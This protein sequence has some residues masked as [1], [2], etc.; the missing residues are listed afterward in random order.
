[1]I[2]QLSHRDRSIRFRL[3][4]FH[5]LI[6]NG[7]LFIIS[8]VAFSYLSLATTS[9]G[10]QA[11][12]ARSYQQ[13]S[14]SAAF[15]KQYPPTASA[16]TLGTLAT[17]YRTYCQPEAAPQQVKSVCGGGGGDGEMVQ[18][19]ASFRPDPA[20]VWETAL[21]EKPIVLYQYDKTTLFQSSR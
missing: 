3:T 21:A 10:A 20:P 5:R 9:E 2:N 8:L 19:S 6:L 14:T 4:K 12:G 17:N 11:A 18:E 15:L 1:M 13:P 7:A 16:A